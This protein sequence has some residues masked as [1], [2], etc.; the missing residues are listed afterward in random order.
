MD[1]FVLLAFFPSDDLLPWDRHLRA[2]SPRQWAFCL[3]GLGHHCHPAFQM[4]PFQ[5]GMPPTVRTSFTI[6]PPVGEAFILLSAI[7]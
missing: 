5:F 1:S 4:I 2:G 3:Q 7:T 6:E